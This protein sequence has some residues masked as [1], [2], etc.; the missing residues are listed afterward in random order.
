MFNLSSG[1]TYTLKEYAQT[2]CDIVDYNYDLIKWDI[3]AFVGSPSKQ[4]FNTHLQDYK[5]TPLKKGLKKTIQYYENSIS[6]SK[7]K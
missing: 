6:S 5:F 4:L 3:N 1:N 2:I 7:Q